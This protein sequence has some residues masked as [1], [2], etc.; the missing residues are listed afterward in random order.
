MNL[1]DLLQQMGRLE[2]AG[3]IYCVS[4]RF[5]QSFMLIGLVRR[6]GHSARI[7]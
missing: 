4:E 1:Y 5:T 3:E 7:G 2:L 6:I